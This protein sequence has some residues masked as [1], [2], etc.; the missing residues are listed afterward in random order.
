MREGGRRG[1][2]DRRPK[3]PHV[4]S[5]CPLSR[6]GFSASCALSLLGVSCLFPVPFS[7]CAWRAY[8][9]YFFTHDGMDKGMCMVVLIRVLWQ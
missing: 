5:L 9:F 7:P 1:T 2:E 4:F 3:G 6:C 8:L